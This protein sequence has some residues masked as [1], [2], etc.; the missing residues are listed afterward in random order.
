[1]KLRW[2]G[3]ALG[4]P[5]LLQLFLSTPVCAQRLP[6]GATP[7]HY[8]LAFVVDI[9]GKRFDGTETINVRIDQ[10]TNRIV[11]NAAEIDFHDVTIKTA[12]GSQRANISLD[13]KAETAA[14]TV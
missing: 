5:L 3:P 10:P 6:G 9:G 13:G 4:I 11:L 12:G 1:M 2:S 7:E 8:D 14:L